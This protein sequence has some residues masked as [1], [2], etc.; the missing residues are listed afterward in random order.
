MHLA[1]TMKRS[2]EGSQMWRVGCVLY[3]VASLGLAISTI[4]LVRNLVIIVAVP[5]VKDGDNLMQ[6]IEGAP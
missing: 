4:C 2:E 5:R 1:I 3:D 6:S